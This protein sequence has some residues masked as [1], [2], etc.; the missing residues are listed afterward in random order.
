MNMTSGE[1]YKENMLLGD[2]FRGGTGLAILAGNGYEDYV[3]KLKANDNTVV[4]AT[5]RQDD[6]NRSLET[7][8]QQF[9]ILKANASE[10]AVT[11]GG[12]VNPAFAGLLGVVNQTIRMAEAWNG[13]IVAMGEAWVTGAPLGQAWS[14]QMERIGGTTAKATIPVEEMIGVQQQFAAELGRTSTA[15]QDEAAAMAAVA[16]ASNYG[17]S[18]NPGNDPNYRDTRPDL[19][20]DA[21]V[22]YV[23]AQAK[24]AGQAA[25][26]A[27]TA[28]K[29]QLKAN[30]D[31][32]MVDAKSYYADQAQT[33][34]DAATA[35]KDI[36]TAAAQA[37]LDATK[38]EI[39]AEKTAYDD[40]AAA[41]IK[42]RQAQTTAALQSLA[43][44]NTAANVAAAAANTSE[45][46]QQAAIQR[47]A[48]ES[49]TA[50]KAQVTS[51]KTAA[52]AG[53]NATHVALD[54]GLKNGIDVA[55]DL[56]TSQAA[57]IDLQVKNRE[58]G[59]ARIVHSQELATASAIAGIEQQK[60]RDLA[61]IDEQV[62]SHELA[63]AEA[64]RNIES[65]KTAALRAV[66][67]ETAAYTKQENDRLKL[68][69]ANAA[70]R[71][72]AL[73]AGIDAEKTALEQQ[74][75]VQQLTKSGGAAAGG[76]LSQYFAA[77]NTGQFDK[78]KSIAAD[79]SRINQQTADEMAQYLLQRDEKTTTAQIDAIHQQ[80]QAQKDGITQQIADF[81]TAE[82]DKKRA[83]N[84]GAASQKQT[85]TD[86][87]ASFKYTESQKKI[88]ITGTADA[89]IKSDQEALASFKWSMAQQLQSY[90][91]GKALEKATDK[92]TLDATLANIATWQAQENARHA[93][94]L[95]K[96]AAQAAADAA[97]IDLLATQRKDAFT[98]ATAQRLADYTDATAKRAAAFLD[99]QQKIT[100][101]SQDDIAAMQKS[102]KEADAAFTLRTKAADDHFKDQQGQIDLTYKQ[103]VNAIQDG[104]KQHNAA[105]DA[106]K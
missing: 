54:A 33:A 71:I 99:A 82:A 49:D 59:D 6:Y 73:T 88:E 53:E 45:G 64:I 80:T 91:D 93:D 94:A 35:T 43:D 21:G 67:E 51:I 87:L 104:L 28:A 36:A 8:G 27:D 22:A 90:K 96:I 63:T 34:K 72:A 95:A 76:L 9:I 42:A 24:E 60:T 55:N 3:A 78:A 47:T 20:T 92:E 68:I 70:A 74:K 10:A 40:R 65:E 86:E 17:P 41:D 100:K 85:L 66:D 7:T 13:T 52:D 106:R 30:F 44:Q 50:W 81:Q 48:D 69:D 23:E 11:I 97:A 79:L 102:Q 31:Q 16:S 101:T 38:T 1:A 39:S 25:V 4:S 84:D 12:H 32:A 14:D 62:H 15:L 98:A 18:V 37:T 83:I 19:S 89:Q 26:A 57:A 61:A 77:D 5:K 29:A 58:E 2:A 103:D 75:A 56:Y 46:V 105:L